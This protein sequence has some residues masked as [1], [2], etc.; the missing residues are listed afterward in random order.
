MEDILKSYIGTKKKIEESRKD[1]KVEIE[2]RFGKIKPQVFN[3]IE[4][5]GEKIETIENLYKIKNRKEVHLREIL[6]DT[7]S[8][9]FLKEQVSFDHL[10]YAT[11]SNKPKLS[12]SIEQAY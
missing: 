5:D 1:Y 10:T 8:V 7:G 4:T 12:L 11:L 3:S 2:I 9:F 6:S